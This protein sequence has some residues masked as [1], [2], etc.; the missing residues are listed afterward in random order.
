MATTAPFELQRRQRGQRQGGRDRGVAE[1]IRHA[2]GLLACVLAVLAAA[3][4]LVLDVAPRFL[5]YRAYTVLGGS[6]APTIPRGSEV[7]L[8]PVRADRLRIGDVITFR[9]PGGTGTL[10]THRIVR[11]ERSDGRRVF[12]TKGDANG[13]PDAWRVPAVGT[14]WRVAFSVPLLGYLPGALTLPLLRL[15]LF[16]LI[17]LLVASSVLRRIWRAQ[18]GTA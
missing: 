14:G 7:V 11:I 3:L 18:P 6:M 15:A 12:V 5:P 13:L 8:R 10:V 1:T 9:K 4:V 16:A 17:S 2:G